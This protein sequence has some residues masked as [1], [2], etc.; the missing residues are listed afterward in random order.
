MSTIRLTQEEFKLLVWEGLDE[1]EP[2]EDGSWE[3][4]YEWQHQGRVVKSN[5]TGKFYLY[6]LSR[7]GSP[8][9]DYYFSY[10]DGGTELQEVELQEKTIVV[11]EWVAV[12]ETD[13]EKV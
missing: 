12:K 7:S 6:T 3:V 8:Y 13:K 9:S 5:T 10:E 4:E 11:K 2:I 1:Y